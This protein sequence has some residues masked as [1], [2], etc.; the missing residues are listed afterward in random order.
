MK[1][2]LGLDLGTNSIGWAVIEINHKEKTVKIIGLGSRILPMNAGEINDFESK[3]KIKSTAAQRTG[4]RGTRRLIERFKLRRDRLHLVLNLLNALP[5]HYKLEIEE[6]NKDG[7]RSGKFRSNKEPKL[8]YL[9]K[10]NRLKAEFLFKESYQEML[11]ELGIENNKGNRIPYDWTLYYLRNKALKSKEQIEIENKKPL[12]LEEFAWVLLSYNQKRG[13]QKTEAL[14][15]TSKEGEIVEALDLQVITV[16]EGRGEKGRFFSIQLNGIDNFS[17]KEYTDKQKTFVGD[18]K[19]VIKTSKVDE[20]GDINKKKVVFKIIDIYPLEIKEI[21][22]KKEEGKHK[23]TLLFSNGWKFEKKPVKNYST[24]Y[25]N[26]INKK[27]DFIIETKYNHKGELLQIQGEDRVF[28]EPD[29]GEKSSDWT[30]LKKKTEKEALAFNVSAG[31]VNTDRNAKKYISPRIYN[32][33]KSDSKTGSRTKIIGGIFQVVDRDF[34]REELTDIIKNQKEVHSEL[35]D[36]ELFESCVELL[37]PQNEQHKRTLLQNRNT[38]QHLL[39]EDILLYQ[40]PLKS[41]KSEIANCK[42][43]IR[44]WK[45][46]TDDN[47]RVIEEINK[48]TGEIKP[49]QIPIYQKVVSTSHPYFQEFRIWDKLHNLKIIQLEIEVNGKKKTNIDVTKDYIKITENWQKLFD[50]L[51][52]QKSL[53]QSQFLDFC[54]K[55][56]KLP[57]NKKQPNF[58]WNFPEDEE[59]KGNE[60]RVSFALRLKR[61]G[62]KDYKDFLTQEKEYDLWHYLYSV[63]YQERNAN[64]KKSLHTI[65]NHFLEGS[66]IDDDIKEKIINDFANYPKF[67]SKYC[68]YSEKALKKLLPLICIGENKKYSWRTEEWFIKWDTSLEERKQEILK[69]LKTID[70]SADEIDYSKSVKTDVNIANN[71]IPFPKGLFNVFKGIESVNDFNNLNLTQASYLLYGRHSELAQAKYW[72]SPKQIRKEL[73]QELKHNSLN[74]PI[75]EKVLLEMMQVVADIWESYGDVDEENNYQKFFDEIHI[76]VGRE[77][78]KSAKEKEKET[79]RQ[80]IAKLQN[81][82]IRQILEEF[83]SESKYGAV[84]KNFDHFERLK[85]IEDGAEHTKNTNKK[86][87]DDK[88]YSK[89]DIEDILKKPKITHLDFEK[90]KLWVEQGYRSPYSGKTITLSDLFDGNKYNIDHVFPQAKITNNSLSNKVVCEL[91]LNQLKKDRTARDFIQ[92]QKGQSHKG[93]P[94]LPEEK[95]I[96]LVKTQFSGTKRMILLAKDIPSGFTNSQ[97]NN[98]RHIARKAME[99]LSHIVR[100]KGEVEFRSKNVLPVTGMVTNELKKAWRLNEVWKDLVRPRFERMNNLTQSSLFGYYEKTKTGKEYFNCKIDDS[101]LE[102]NS[103]YDIK[104][105]DHRHHSLDALIIALCT[106]EH[107]N[108]I[109]NIKADSRSDNYEKQKQIEKYRTTLKRKIKYSKPNKENHKD[110]DWYY[111]LPGEKRENGLDNSRRDSVITMSYLYNNENFG[112][113][114]NY[115]KMIFNVLQDTIVTFKQNLR[116]LNKRVNYYKNAPN[117]KS[118]WQEPR[119]FKDITKSENQY[120]W[121]VRR[122]LGE[123]TYY[124]KVY[125]GKTENKQLHKYLDKIYDYPEI[126]IDNK[127]QNQI[128]EIKNSSLSFEE[129]KVKIKS[130]FQNKQTKV[131]VLKMAIRKPLDTSF[132]SDKIETITDTG[133]QEI[134]FNHMAQFDTVELPFDEAVNYYDALLEKY[135]LEAIIKNPEND[136]SS[137]AELK[138]YFRNNN[139]KYGKTDYKNLNVFV[140]KINEIDFRNDKNHKIKEHPEIAFTPEEIEKMNRQANLQQLN[141]GKKHTPIKKVRIS[142]GFGNQRP[143]SNNP[144]SVKSKQY[145]VND[146]GSNLYLGVYERTYINEKD[147]TIKERKFKDI[148]LI[149]LIEALKLD[150]NNRYNPL[151]DKIFDDKQNEYYRIFSLSPLDLVYVPNKEES[152]SQNIEIDK[153]DKNRIYKVVNFSGVTVNFIPYYMANE[154]FDFDKSKKEEKKMIQEIQYLSKTV[155]QIPSPKTKGKLVDLTNEIG[156]S[157]HQFKSPNNTIEINSYENLN[158]IK[159][160]KDTCWRLKVNRLGHITEVN[161]GNKIIKL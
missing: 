21:N 148:G 153:I 158:S 55:E 156:L 131:K 4:Y 111:M 2:I 137:K 32:I 116:V 125:L 135:E 122:S 110:N 27:Y 54:K 44:Y 58:V 152:V 39:V 18:L 33:L 42:Y 133:I 31:F 101:I 28:R 100:E 20:Q 149:E 80:G 11:D 47:G 68:A 59:L 94:V 161:T 109:N 159:S 142:S 67:P 23:Y 121:G 29:Y 36:R 84:P 150:S 83:L 43:E 108:Y 106:P 7:K 123:K 87:F 26:V 72:T 96:D 3:G 79:K 127:L 118:A 37:Y 104:R 136:I 73:H 155:F 14:D 9:P 89:K 56:F 119:T 157:S 34:Y 61:N 103:S 40:R 48:E 120:N 132:N 82:R 74:N 62:F 52:N 46:I 77:L 99:L 95:Y 1:R 130:S 16:S 93:I 17:Y 90:Y 107:V 91:E 12:T 78:K 145:V 5:E 143:L 24:K 92:T 128:L 146:A 13:Y 88:T 60:T 134:L 71:E 141:N 81:K 35:N 117:G 97:L 30:L 38:I 66:N 154:L 112:E 147:E 151:P 114:Y 49:K 85:I 15:L 139:Y 8:A 53:T 124:G 22:Y 102:K 160:V 63:G 69:R 51:N 70:F 41:K 144:D 10:K 6:F 75:A 98:A 138:V 140:E 86:F 129:F 65:F 105:I 57:Y 113:E 25:K 45:T 19:E 64:N 115:K 126:I 76:E 50:K